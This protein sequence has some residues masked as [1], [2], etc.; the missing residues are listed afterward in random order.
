MAQPRHHRGSLG[1]TDGGPGHAVPQQGRC[2]RGDLS[3]GPRPD[4]AVRAG[5]AMEHAGSAGQIPRK[6]PRVTH[7]ERV[8]RSCGPIRSAPGSRQGWEMRPY[9]RSR[10]G[11]SSP[12]VTAPSSTFF[13]MR[14]A[15]VRTF[16]VLGLLTTGL[17]TVNEAAFAQVVFN[18]ANSH[19]YEFVATPPE[20]KWTEAR[21]AAE[22]RTLRATNGKLLPGYLP[23]ITPGA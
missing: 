9:R 13:L 5:R 11:S 10:L 12:P 20:I 17:L 7:C 2:Y 21:A 14:Q 1:T 6:G 4:G 19:Y 3:E 18:P 22:R 15:M 23:T 16:R 8:E